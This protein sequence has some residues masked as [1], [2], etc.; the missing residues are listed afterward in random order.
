M[1]AAAR[2]RVREMVRKEVRQLIRDPRTRLMIFVAPIIQLIM[3]GYA[4]NTDIKNTA[5]H[6]M[7][8]DGTAASRELIDAFRATGYFAVERWARRPAE[9][10]QALDRGQATLAIEI[11][12]GFAR[13]LATGGPARVQVLVDGSESNTATVAQAYAQR[14][15]QRFGLDRAARAGALPAGGIDLRTRAW[16]N[17]NLESRTYNV[18][19]VVGVL[20]LLMSLLLTALSVVRERELGTLDQLM[21][22]PLEPREFIAGKTLPVA[23]VGVIDLVLISLVAVYWFDIPIRGSRLAL[24]IAA[25]LYILAGISVGLLISSI[26]KTQQ[27]AFMTM[28]LFVLPA[29]ILSGFFYPISSMPEVFQ[30]LT[31]LNPVRHFLEIIRAIFLK[32][33]G[34]AGLWS[35][36]LALTGIAAVA[37][38]AAVRRLPKTVAS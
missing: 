25:L 8:H 38:W 37:F 5:T 2:L 36:Y 35:Q 18:P 10:S 15:I 7:D 31:L 22:S 9:L 26:S 20:V 13:S 23:L 3:F 17:P 33:Q 24:L 4:V 32:G 11:P 29:I 21:V 27:E 28:F 34:M 30:W 12:R 6:V 19:A 1:S 14:I 16:Y